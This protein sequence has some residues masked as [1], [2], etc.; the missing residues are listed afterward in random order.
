MRRW[1]RHPQQRTRRNAQTRGGLK[2]RRAKQPLRGRPTRLLPQP[3]S[4]GQPPA[5]AGPEGRWTGAL[6]R[7]G[8]VEREGRGGEFSCWRVWLRPGA[9]RRSFNLVPFSF[10]LS[11]T[12]FI[13]NLQRPRSTRAHSHASTP[14]TVPT[15]SAYETRPPALKSIKNQKKKKG[16]NTPPLNPSIKPRRLQTPGNPQRDPLRRWSSTGAPSL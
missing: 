4:E 10:R 6:V 13:H 11:S 5:G 15:I 14:G 8:C 12:I 2:R 9:P 7:E 3:A 16:N 1:T